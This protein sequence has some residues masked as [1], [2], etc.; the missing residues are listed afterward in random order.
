MNSINN[1]WSHLK[2]DFYAGGTLPVPTI[3]DGQ[4]ELLLLPNNKKAQYPKF[5]GYLKWTTLIEDKPMTIQYPVEVHNHVPVMKYVPK[6][7]SEHLLE[8]VQ[9]LV[10]LLRSAGYV[11]PTGE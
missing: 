8:G 11:F 10:D 4:D 7:P 5:L 3:S 1:A 2:T 9:L 6:M